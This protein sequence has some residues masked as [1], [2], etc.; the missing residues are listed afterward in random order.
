MDRTGDL[1]P[2]WL[3]WAEWGVSMAPGPAAA[4]TF[5]SGVGGPVPSAPVAFS[6]V[7]VSPLLSVQKHKARLFYSAGSHMRDP[8]LV[9]RPTKFSFFADIHKIWSTPHLSFQPFLLPT[10]F[11]CFAFLLLLLPQPELFSGFH[12]SL[13]VVFAIKFGCVF[14]INS[15]F[16]GPKIK[17]VR[18]L[19][20]WSAF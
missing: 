7:S 9:L 10:S 15:C 8:L 4:T 18:G 17:M 11:C 16:G 13:K 1:P 5:C 2:H 20:L 3:V 14:F 19:H 12:L 6:V